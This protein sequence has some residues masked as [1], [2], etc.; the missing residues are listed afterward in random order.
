ME[1]ATIKPLL[2]SSWM[3]GVQQAK[4]LSLSYFGHFVFDLIHD[5]QLRIALEQAV[6]PGA[7][8]E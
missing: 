6:S 4:S 5:V 1:H 2:H 3:F 8:L 7:H